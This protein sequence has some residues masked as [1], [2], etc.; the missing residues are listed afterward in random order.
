MPRYHCKSLRPGGP[1]ESWCMRTGASSLDSSLYNC[2]GVVWGHWILRPLSSAHTYFALWQPPRLFGGALVTIWPRSSGAGSR[3]GFRFMLVLICCP[4]YW[5]LQWGWLVYC[6]RFI[7]KKKKRTINYNL[8]VCR[9]GVQGLLVF[10]FSSR[11]FPM[12]G[13]DNGPFLCLLERCQTDL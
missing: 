1:L 12:S 8:C 7:I 11:S 3:R 4:C 9:D 6:Y 10:V 2:F 5:G 13:V